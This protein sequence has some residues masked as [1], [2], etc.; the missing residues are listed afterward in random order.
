MVSNNDYSSFLGKEQLSKEDILTLIPQREPFLMV[1]KVIKLDISDKKLLAVKDIKQEEYYFKGHFPN[2]PIM[3]GVLILEAMAQTSSIIGRLLTKNNGT[4][5]F[6]EI[7]EAKFLSIVRPNCQL[8]IEAKIEKI[9]D[10]FLLASC[11]A[12]VENSIVAYAK[13]KAFRK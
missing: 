6:A 1:D 5:M 9:R 10:P 13:I 2:N 7:E 12:F 4:I 8:Q 11:K 3:P